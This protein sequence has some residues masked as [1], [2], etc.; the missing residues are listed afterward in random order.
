[1]AAPQLAIAKAALSASLFRADPTSLSRPSV[2]T[3]FS[4]LDAATTQC[5]R[6]NV[7]KC[8]AWIVDH[9]AQSRGRAGALGKYLVALS[10]SLE[11]QDGSKPSAKRR[12]LHLLYILSDA[13]HH[14]VN[15]KDDHTLE[16]SLQTS[17]PSLV[18]YASAFKDSPKHTQKLEQLIQLWEERDYVSRTLT[19]KLRE[20]LSGDVPGSDDIEPQTAAGAT[21]LKIAK[22]APFVLPSYHGDASTP[23]FDLPA[24]T[25]LPHLTPNSTKP[26]LPD[27]IQPIRLNSGPAD[28]IL[29][30]AVQTL[31]SDV[32][33]IFSKGRSWDLSDKDAQHVD[34]NQLGEMVLID[35]VTGDTVGGETY[36]GWSR[37]FCEKMKERRRKAKRGIAQ[38]RGSRSRSRSDDSRS[39]S[40]STSPPGFS[41]RRRSSSAGSRG[42]DRRGFSRG[43]RSRSPRKPSRGFSHQ[44]SPSRS[45]SRS[46][47][48]YQ[49]DRR[50]S[51][52]RYHTSHEQPPAQQQHMA[53]YHVPPPQHHGFPSV[54]PVGGFPAPPPP[55]VGYQGPWP[56]PPP[57]PPAL[58][59]GVPNWF[60]ASG[61]A[62]ATWNSNAPPPPPPTGSSHQHGPWGQNHQGN[63]SRAGNAY[64][65]RGNY[66]RGRG[67]NW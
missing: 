35:E 52:G 27:L 60:P 63:N 54:P 39:R 17:L 25:W 53:P 66:G 12:R 3:F 41:R 30:E 1:M 50:H 67:G 57:P 15:T 9:I 18:A 29:T 44:R 6:P 51:P 26:M 32:D 45:R 56:P 16:E 43:S 2:E 10:K 38:D 34:T 42:N 19:T 23:W 46:R 22:E 65:S 13:L 37:Q 49:D 11:T 28:K 55:P 58:G 40:R 62:P 14:T 64:Q 20:A 21:S 47:P 5:S 31:L 24:S 48:R 4:L 8:R 61:F 59:G 36:Y 7:Q 33:R